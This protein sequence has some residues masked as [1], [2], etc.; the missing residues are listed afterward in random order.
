MGFFSRERSHGQT[1]LVM[2]QTFVCFLHSGGDQTL[3][4]W[5]SH[6]SLPSRA[7]NPRSLSNLS[8]RRRKSTASEP[9]S[10]NT[11]EDLKHI[12]GRCTTRTNNTQTKEVIFFFVKEGI[13]ELSDLNN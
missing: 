6:L 13:R 9:T 2:W 4:K 5:L 3:P 12:R 10:W 1:A 11:S 7:V 8:N